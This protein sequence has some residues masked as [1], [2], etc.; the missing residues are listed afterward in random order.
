MGDGRTAGHKYNMY[1]SPEHDILFYVEEEVGF[2][3]CNCYKEQSIISVTDRLYIIFV[4]TT[5]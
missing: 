1:S 5:F 4:K 3:G 2:V